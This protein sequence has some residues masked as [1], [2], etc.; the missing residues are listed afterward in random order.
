MIK[1]VG[2]LDPSRGSDVLYVVT[3]VANPVRYASRYRLYRQ[4]AR[5]MKARHDVVHITVELAFGDRQFE[6]TEAGNPHHIQ[7]RT[8][9][10]IWH[11]EN[12]INLAVARLPA[13]WK[14]VAWVDADV[15]FTNPHWNHETLH[16]LQHHP[17][18]QLFQ[19]AIDMGPTGQ[20]LQ[21][22]AGF[23]HQHVTRAPRIL[24]GKDGYGYGGHYPFWHPG[25]G[26]ACTRA[27]WDGMG[28]LIDWAILGS[29]DHHM[30]LCFIGDGVK[31]LPKG[32]HPNYADR[33]RVFQER[34]NQHIRGN[35]GFVEGTLLHHWHG[36]KK[37]RKYVERW[38]VLLKNKFDPVRDLKRDWQ[39]LLQLR[40][41]ADKLRS[42][43]RMYF[44]NRNEDSNDLE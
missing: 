17:I 26:W 27:A 3:P 4:F 37:D 38:D 1:K 19:S 44:R 5:R 32:V 23:A 41:G 43:C 33:L 15:E 39:G 29:S 22:H 2:K 30:A 20:F 9:E 35:I 18:V 6:V 13:D 10:E 28:G 8:S 11:K 16:Q 14:Y 12:M 40:H 31:S 42:E 24:N 36:K 21:D 25:F 7:L 34:C